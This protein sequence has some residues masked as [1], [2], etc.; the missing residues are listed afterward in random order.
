M[1]SGGAGVGWALLCQRT[2]ESALVF[3][4]EKEFLKLLVAEDSR[5]GRDQFQLADP[6]VVVV[7][8]EE[9]EKA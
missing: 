1:Q 6:I 2:F 5:E 8:A 4:L 7:V 9:E 3:F